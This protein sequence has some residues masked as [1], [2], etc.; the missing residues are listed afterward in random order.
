[1]SDD[2]D[3]AG[4]KRA[5]LIRLK[6]SDCGSE[7]VLIFQNF[8]C[9]SLELPWK[10]NQQNISCIPAGNYTVR[11]RMSPKYGRIY[12]ILEVPGRSY[13]LIHSGNWAGDVSKGFKTHTN[14]CILLGKY[15]GY[16]QGQRAVLCSRPT[17]TKFM[18]LLQGQSFDLNILDTI[19]EL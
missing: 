13:I 10:D 19:A 2:T 14:G 7:G 8:H 5:T 1:M 4:S 16:L 12:W 9:Y 17:I 11:I 15:T 6:R 18:N 3:S